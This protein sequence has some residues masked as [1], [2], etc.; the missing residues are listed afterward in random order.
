VLAI[1]DVH[2][3]TPRFAQAVPE[4]YRAQAANAKWSPHGP[5][6]TVYTWAE[7]DEAMRPV[8][9][10]ILFNIAQA[11][12][13]NERVDEPYV[14]PAAQA[15]DEAAAFIRTNPAKYIGF[16]TV[17][18]DDPGALDEL[19]R[20]V[21]DLGL[22]GI[23]LGLNY[24][25]VDPLSENAFRIFAEAERRHLPVLLHQGTSPVQFADIDYAHP[26]H[27]DRIAMAFPDLTIIMAHIGHPFYVDAIAVARKHQH[28][29]LDISGAVL[30]RYGFFQAMVA[31]TEWGV[32]DKILFA[33]DYPA[34]TPEETLRLLRDVN[35][36]APGPNAMRIPDKT[37][38]E[39]IHRDSLALLRLD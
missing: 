32:L 5:R 20:A 13:G 12:S 7:Y 11:P 8:D 1:I 16:L 39:I 17:H 24:Q 33:S 28:V 3:H 26:R 35:S 27:T 2:T 19:D 9:R 36:G 30:R 4:E 14:L 10:A 23:K 22:R 15:N 21:G 29:F 6:P 37:I 34:S 25:N 31:C 38:D 18:P